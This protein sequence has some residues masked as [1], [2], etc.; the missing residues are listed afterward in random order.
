MKT[1]IL[2][3]VVLLLF[4][5]AMLCPVWA[6]AITPLDPD[7]DASLTLYYQKDGHAFSD[8][9]IGI[10]RVAQAFPDGTFEL[11]L[12]YSA[13]PLNIHGITAQEQ[14]QQIAHTLYSYIVANR[15]EPDR[16]ARTDANG[17]VC[18]TDL[19]TGLYFVREVAA[20]NEDGTY[21][22][23][24]FLVYLPTPHP[25]GTFDYAVEARPKCTGFVPSDRYTVTKLWQDAGKQE[26]RPGQVTVDIYR[27]GELQD[28]QILSAANNWTYT[29]Q[30]LNGDFGQWS[31]A[32]REVPAPYKVAIQ[33]SGS[34]FSIVNIRHT[35]TEIPYTGDSFSPLPYILAMC[36][37]G[38]MLVI[39]GIY[40]WRRK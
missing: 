13:Y 31:V 4:A 39:L 9:E 14:W 23:N 29:W 3:L 30:V 7:A 24:N 40:R 38:V 16:E 10:Y 26:D 27:N 12:P 32:E 15:E 22:F 17:T 18:F 8:L 36:F 11:V 35:P 25:D 2:P 34:T 37:S 19:E 33:Q 20:V 6:S 28:T 5:V 1:R 21:I